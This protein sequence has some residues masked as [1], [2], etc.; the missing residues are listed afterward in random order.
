MNYREVQQFRQIWIWLFIILLTGIAWYSF[1]QQII[2]RRQFG[3]NPAPDLVMWIIWI[4]VGIGFPLFFHA[5]R[6]IVEVRKDGVYIRFSPLHYRFHRIPLT[7]LKSYKVRNYSPIKEYGGWGIRYGV[8]GKA[9]NVSGNRGVQLEL[10][11]GK[12]LLIGSQKPEEL[13]MAIDLA[14]KNRGE[15]K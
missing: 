7:E 4:V 15:N 6:L 5:M 3:S 13:A 2:F 11:N 10:L 8:K 9:Y 14:I 1:F 12:R